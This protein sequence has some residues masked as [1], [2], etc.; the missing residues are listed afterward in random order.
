[1]NLRTSCCCESSGITLDGEPVLSAVC[2]CDNC[3]KR[4][5]SAFGISVYFKNTQVTS[6]FGNTEVYKISNEVEQE[7]L[8]CKTCGTTIYWKTSSFPE[9]I[10]VAGGCFSKETMPGPEYTL[11]NENKCTWL[12]LPKHIK[13]KL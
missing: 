13:N 11:S 9:H 8:F 5:G 1:M 12:N 2:H 4:T 7:R 10:G 6:R 3:K